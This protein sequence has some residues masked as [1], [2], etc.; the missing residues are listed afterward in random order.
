MEPID[1]KLYSDR[2]LHITFGRDMMGMTPFEVNYLF[3]RKEEMGSTPEGTH[4]MKHYVADLQWRELP[5]AE[6]FMNHRPLLAFDRSVMGKIA[7]MARYSMGEA[8]TPEAEA[9]RREN[10]HLR[11]QNQKLIDTLMGVVERRTK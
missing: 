7:M 1:K 5:N 6:I 3:M 11:A 2:E 4:Y 10:D 8:Q 9:L